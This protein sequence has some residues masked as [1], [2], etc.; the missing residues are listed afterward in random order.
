ME[1]VRDNILY[2]ADDS[3][4]IVYFNESA[5]KAF[6]SMELGKECP[7]AVKIIS[8][9]FST[10]PISEQNSTCHTTFIGSLFRWVNFSIAQ[11]E[12][13]GHGK[14]CVYT[15]T[16]YN[17]F[18]REVLS[19]LKPMGSFNFSMEMNL[20]KDQYILI[21]E[22]NFDKIDF[23]SI[24]E[25][26]LSTAIKR[27]CEKMVHPDDQKKFLEFMD[28]DS[29]LERLSQSNGFV[30]T[31]VRE[32]NSRGLWDEVTITLF[33][34]EQTFDGTDI[35]IAFFSINSKSQILN[36]P[37]DSEKNQLTGLL[38]KGS[39]IEAAK[40]FLA[41]QH[42]EVCLI[43]MDVEHFRFFNKW[44]SR[45]QGDR[46]LKNIAYFLHEV[47]RLFDCVAGYGGGDDFY[48]IMDKHP[49]TLDYLV[50]GLNRLI[51][52]FD[53]IEGFKIAFG[54]YTFGS[55]TEEILD[56]IDFADTAT[57]A[58][59]EKMDGTI[60]WFSPQ[61]IKEI[62][63][64]LQIIP[65]IKRGLEEDEFTF[66]LQPKCSIK[67]NK[68]VGA[69]ALV[70]W[71]NK[72][73]GL[74]SPGEFIPV[75]EKNCM[76]AKVDMYIWEKV[77]K[78]IRAW[79]DSGVTPVPVSINVSRID[80]FSINV[81]QVFSSL[82]E[83]YKIDPKFIEIEITE[84]AFI[85]DIK[86]LRT[87]IQC[88]RNKGFMILIDDFGSGYSSLNM[89]KD[90]Q[91]DVLKMDIKFFDLNTTNYDKGISIIKS[92]IDLSHN[93]KVPVIAEGVETKNQIDILKELGLNYVQGFYYYRPIPIEDYERLICDQNKISYN[94]LKLA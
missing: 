67:D 47:E 17:D 37:S 35:V 63:H 89:L 20:G 44:Y 38:K 77:C 26:P 75:L 30:S 4:T 13:P 81:P 91:A 39:F 9:K 5:K 85:D 8:D 41:E 46:L 18:A 7:E 6:P 51:S 15:G 42:N 90:V 57:K 87:V 72:L 71:K 73:R 78:T 65:E 69:E 68:I 28:L 66:F 94:G 88:L 61:M 25:E 40:D 12:Y 14:C 21:S 58:R 10:L 54:G 43:S 1:K 36:V 80:I 49:S 56:A 76:I 59:L 22:R 79:I 52:S 55:Q 70:R 74:V 24:A 60:C 45:W 92:V 34:G 62:E 82:V 16:F 86:I 2:I 23:H 32:K 29:V 64:D 93:M 27:T 31:M 48:I 11:M 83:K 84:S 19:R 3:Q 50:N 33:Q 53:G